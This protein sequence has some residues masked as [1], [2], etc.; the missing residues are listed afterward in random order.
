MTTVFCGLLASGGCHRPTHQESKINATNQWNDVRARVKQQL[1][2]QQFD[3]GLF[4]EAIANATAALALSPKLGKSYVL[5]AFANLELGQSAS[6]NAAI[7]HALRLGIVNG[8]IHYVRGVL[9]EQRGEVDRAVMEFARAQEL[10][11]DRIEYLLAHAECLATL[12][13][14]DEA[15]A[16]LVE[17][18]DHFDESH[19]IAKLA[20]RIAELNGDRAQAI[21]YYS[22]ALVRGSPDP[23]VSRSLGLNLA[24]E[25]RCNEA[26]AVLSPLV[27]GDVPPVAGEGTIRRKLAGCLLKTD[28]AGRAVDV[29]A[30]YAVS[31]PRDA[32]ATALR[33]T[34]LWRGG[35]PESALVV[36][37]ENVFSGDAATDLLCLQGEILTD[38]GR[39]SE[40]SEAFLKALDGDPGH[41][42][43]IAALD[44]LTPDRASQ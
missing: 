19:E 36:L 40:A 41:T 21:E 26:I 4:K 10:D 35:H 31:H 9:F 34:A 38:L 12:D 43:A 44:R 7:M 23:S 13:R 39:E 16:M 6:A 1:A 5:I 22:M 28:M 14:C 2:Q 8:D 29:I 17:D 18:L 11:G 32:A 42:W 15:I 20:A 27:D 30:D 33:A 3:Q 25:D 24:S 37:S